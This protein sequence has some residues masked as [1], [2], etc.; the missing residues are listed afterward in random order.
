MKEYEY[1][2][3]EETLDHN[4]K[5]CYGSDRYDKNI[6]VD[7][8]E[9][10]AVKCSIVTV[11]DWKCVVLRNAGTTHVLKVSSAIAWKLIWWSCLWVRE[12]NWR[13]CCCTR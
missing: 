6:N 7:D 11:S 13:K 9:D 4:D 12:H 3:R 1:M 5:L 2:E 10:G 8:F